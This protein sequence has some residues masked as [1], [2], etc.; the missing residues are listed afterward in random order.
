MWWRRS[1]AV[2]LQDLRILRRE[3]VPLL[4]FILMPFTVMAFNQAPFRLILRAQGFSTANGAEQ[5]VPGIAVLFAFFLTANV[6]LGIFR[7]HGWGTWE[8][9]RASWA[10]PAEI[11][12]GKA[13][14]PLLSV[15]LQLLV[16][17]GV[18]S[19]VFHV[20]IRGSLY[21]LAAVAAALALALVALGFALAAVCNSLLQLNAAANL[22]ALLFGGL[23]GAIAPVNLLPSWAR[24]VAPATPSYWAIRGFRD[25]IL[26]GAGLSTVAI[27]IAALTAFAVAFATIALARFRID[28]TKTFE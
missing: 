10:T 21:A 20:H 5:A 7:E 13:V 18:G 27:D 24:A 9:L 25:I 8:R 1:S 6:G 26:N 17:L 28:D 11:L 23:G 19:L 22:G 12:L 2:A 3:P 15:G 16:L 4:V 14:T